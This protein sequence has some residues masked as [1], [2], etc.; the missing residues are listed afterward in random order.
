MD[1]TLDEEL[2]AVRDLARDILTGEASTERIREVER[3]ASQWDGQLWK[4][5]A[6]AGLLGIALPPEHGGSGLGLGALSVLLTEQ[7][8]CLAPVPLWSASIAALTLA[9]H[10][11]PHQR[12]AL[13]AGAADGS[14]RLTLAL[15]EDAPADPAAPECR[16]TRSTDGWQLTGTKILVP[17]PTGTAGVLVSA[18][19]A[20]GTGLFLVRTDVQGLTWERAESTANGATAHLTLHGV[21]AH[22]LGPPGS[23]VLEW[24]LRRAVLGLTATQVGV[25]AGATELAA[26][27]LGERN[28]FGRPL[29]SFQA[30]QH[31]LADCY[32]DIEAMRVTLWQAVTALEDGFV[33]DREV[34]VAQWWASQAGV[35]IVHRTQH[36]HGGIGVDVDYPAHRFFLWGRELATTLGGAL[37]ALTELGEVLAS[38]EVVA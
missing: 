36:A 25:V 3:S 17:F 33:G 31:H 21:E 24:T 19:A 14:T 35:D 32:I 27:Y 5:L 13:L 34:L 37:P 26:D 4:T 23:G 7:G 16:A 12:A 28:Q 15:E 10:G 8:R 18:T 2:A 29:G 6:E 20:E 38:R 22:A 11:D 30:L 9:T 1:F